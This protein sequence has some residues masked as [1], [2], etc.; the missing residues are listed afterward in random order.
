MTGHQLPTQEL[1]TSTNVTRVVSIWRHPQYQLLAGDNLILKRVTT[2]PSE[3]H[4]TTSS[5]R[6]SIVAS[7]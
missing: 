4:T 5:G 6:K 7:R 1:C 3:E 2:N